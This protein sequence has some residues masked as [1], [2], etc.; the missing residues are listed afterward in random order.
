M[1]PRKFIDS[2]GIMKN[3]NGKIDRVNLKDNYYD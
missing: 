2:N 3:K 1:L